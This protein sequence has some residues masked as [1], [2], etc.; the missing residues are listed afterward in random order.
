MRGSSD[1]RYVGG[2]RYDCES[3][4]AAETFGGGDYAGSMKGLEL[5]GSELPPRFVLRYKGEAT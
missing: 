5:G 4:P 1:W 2:G 3:R